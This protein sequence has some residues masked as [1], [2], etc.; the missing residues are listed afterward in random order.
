MDE[1]VFCRIV[2]GEIPVHLVWEDEHV[3][4][5]DDNAP[6]A[7]VHTLVVPRTHFV[8]LSDDIPATDTVAIFSAVS[9]VAKVKGVDLSGYR[10]IVNNGPDAC[11]TV[12]HLH[13]HVLG[14]RCL[15][16]GMVTVE[17]E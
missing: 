7:P 6:Q 1:C 8:N 5:F 4:A 14:G 2:R 10:V 12:A 3:I 11:Q 9:Q 15:G 16:H 17:D 13:V